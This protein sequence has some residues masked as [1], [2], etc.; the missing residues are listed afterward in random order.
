[1]LKAQFF[2]SFQSFCSIKR[3]AYKLKL[4]KKCKILLVFYVSLLKQNIIRKKQVEEIT[5][6]LQFK[7]NNDKNYKVKAM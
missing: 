7:D 3:Q 5:S 4:P 6:C 1:M 2:G